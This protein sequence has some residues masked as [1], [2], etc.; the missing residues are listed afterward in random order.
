MNNKR[1]LF[2]NDWKAQ[3]EMMTDEQVRRF[4]Y[5]LINFSEG[6][7]IELPTTLEQALW[8]GVLP[9]LKINQEKYEK[10]V[11]AN[12][13]NGKLGGR[14]PKLEDN[15]L[16]QNPENPNGF[17][18]NPN[19]LI[20]DKRQL[21]NDNCKEITDKGEKETGNSQQINYKSKPIIDKGENKNWELENKKSELI[22]DTDSNELIP[23][24]SIL[25]KDKPIGFFSNYIPYILKNYEDWENDIWILSIEEFLSKAKEIDPKVNISE[26]YIIAYKYYKSNDN[27]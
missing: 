21:I 5:N 26:E 27:E 22:I 15:L 13:L 6:K 2:Y 18:Q 8:I 20:N 9:S 3:M 1:F 4:V 10:R 11:E 23:G 24:T 19:N 12:K 16:K 17:Y 7:K 25:K 14:P